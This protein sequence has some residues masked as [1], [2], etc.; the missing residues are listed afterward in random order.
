MAKIVLGGMELKQS[1]SVEEK[2]PFSMVLWGKSGCG[3]TTLAA[4]APGKKLWLLFDPGGTDSINNFINRGEVVVLDTTDKPNA[5][6]ERFIN[7]NPLGLEQF[8]DQNPDIE[9]IVFDS[10]TSFRERCLQHAP[11]KGKAI[12]VDDPGQAGYGYRNRW[13]LGCVFHMLRLSQK[14]KRNII[15]IVHEDAP[16][17][18]T[19]GQVVS[20]SMLLGGS[21]VEEVPLNFSEVWHMKDNGGKRSIAVRPYGFYTPMKTRMF[22]TDKGTIF[23]WPYN[24]DTDTGM[25]LS[26]MYDAWK[27]SNYEKIPLP[28]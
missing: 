5:I 3:K 2:R 8:L 24:A 18:D 11:V 15:F 7:E 12:A 23:E 4:T 10:T 13:T 20:I 21:L 9:T 19:K 22:K 26:H 17:K 25:R 16:D 27:A 1:T 14:K 28:K 6:V